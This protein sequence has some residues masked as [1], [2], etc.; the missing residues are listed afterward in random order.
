MTV[1]ALEL[2]ATMRNQVGY[3]YT[4]ICGI[5]GAETAFEQDV[6][7]GFQRAAGIPHKCG[8]ITFTKQRDCKLLCPSNFISKV[9]FA[10]PLCSTGS[11]GS[12]FEFLQG[13]D[14]PPSPTHLRFPQTP[15]SAGMP[16][17]SLGKPDSPP[18]SFQRN[19]LSRLVTQGA[20]ERAS[21][22]SRHKQPREWMARF[23]RPTST[24][25][26]G[27]SPLCP[28]CRVTST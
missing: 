17:V 27:P 25:D 6:L 5:I 24:G 19:I 10:T 2:L 13:C 4:L 18:L 15:W 3:D 9:L 7:G 16:H 23:H 28:Q 12:T 1:L 26:V 14:R 8:S 22:N 11:T 21:T 20:N